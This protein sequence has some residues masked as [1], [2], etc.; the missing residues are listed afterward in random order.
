MTVGAPVALGAHYVFDGGAWRSHGVGSH[1]PNPRPGQTTHLWDEEARTFG[2]PP[3]APLPTMPTFHP[4]GATFTGPD[5]IYADQI[6][7]QGDTLTQIVAKAKALATDPARMYTLVLSAR[8]YSIHGFTDGL[9]ANAGVDMPPNVQLWGAGSGRHGGPV[10]TI[11]VE[12]DT[13]TYTTATC[14]WNPNDPHSTPKLQVIRVSESLPGWGIRHVRV[15]CG[16]QGNDNNGRGHPYNGIRFEE[17]PNQAIAENVVVQGNRGYLTHPPGETGFL[18]T[19]LCPDFIF[20]NIEMDG[21]ELGYS[22]G[23][24]NQRVSSTGIMVNESTG[25]IIDATYH[26]TWCGGTVATWWS[27]GVATF[28]VNSYEVG[29]GNDPV[30]GIQGGGCLNHERADLCSHYSTKYTLNRIDRGI[31]SMGVTLNND[32][33]WDGANIS[34]TTGVRG[35]LLLVDTANDP[36]SDVYDKVSVA[37]WH[38]YD[39]LSLG[40][41]HYQRNSADNPDGQPM[42]MTRRGNALPISTNKAD[43]SWTTTT[44]V[45]Y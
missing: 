19:Y 36:T 44:R 5:A 16:K 27:R 6:A 4:D 29:G 7:A 11:R 35:R 9:N 38:P 20:R 17:C 26:H 8:T 14:L 34:T 18:T 31:P 23:D 15:A 28:N 1:V 45:R 30:E 21:R 40:A 22:G 33:L 41:G 42:A 37:V 13:S 2:I 3:L 32:T 24:V 25:V 10:T 12:P 43:G 39:P